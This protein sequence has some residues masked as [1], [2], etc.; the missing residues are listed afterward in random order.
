MR[1]WTLLHDAVA[2][3]PVDLVVSDMAHN[4]TGIDVADAARMTHLIELAMD[5]AL[6]HL[7]P[8]GALVTKVFHGSGLQPAG[9]AVQETLQGGQAAQ[10]KGVA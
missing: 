3:R 5:F 7:Q 2:G 6:T 9:R 4:L 10:T 8:G 1:C